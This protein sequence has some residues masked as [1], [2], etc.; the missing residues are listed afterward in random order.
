MKILSAP[1][2]PTTKNAVIGIFIIE[3]DSSA[4]GVGSALYQTRGENYIALIDVY[5]KKYPPHMTNY[6]NSK[7]ELVGLALSVEHWDTFARLGT[8]IIF[9]DYEKIADITDKPITN[10]LQGRMVMLLNK[11]NLII[12]HRQGSKQLIS[13]WQSRFPL[14]NMVL[15]TNDIIY[16]KW[17]S[18]DWNEQEWIQDNIKDTQ[19]NCV[20]PEMN[21]RKINQINSKKICTLDGIIEEYE[22][23][24]EMEAYD[25]RL[26]KLVQQARENTNILGYFSN[27]N[28]ILMTLRNKKR[29]NYNEND[30][31]NNIL[32]GVVE[33]DNEVTQEDSKPCNEEKQ[34]K[35]E[36]LDYVEKGIYHKQ[37]DICGLNRKQVR[38]EQRWDSQLGIMM[39]Y[40]QD[41]GN[42][43]KNIKDISIY[44]NINNINID[45]QKLY[46]TK[47][48]LL[49][50][51]NKKYYYNEYKY[52]I[53][54][55]LA[56]VVIAYVHEVNGHKGIS[57]TITLIYKQFMLLVSKTFITKILQSCKECARIA[58]LQHI[59]QYEMKSIIPKYPFYSIHMDTKYVLKDIHGMRY[60]HG[61][62]DHFSKYLILASSKDM[63]AET[64]LT[65]TMDKVLLVFGI[66]ERYIIDNA[67]NLNDE[68]AEDI[69]KIVGI[70]NINTSAYYSRSNGIIE[71]VWKFIDRLI[72]LY[73]VDRWSEY[74]V[75]IQYLWN[76]DSKEDLAG[77]NPSHIIF[78]SLGVIPILQMNNLMNFQ[79]LKELPW[80]QN[81]KLRMSKWIDAIDITVQEIINKVMDSKDKYYI[82]QNKRYS[83]QYKDINY[84]PGDLVK[85]RV[86]Y[87]LF[88]KQSDNWET[89]YM[90]IEDKGTRVMIKEVDTGVMTTVN[91]N[92][93]RPLMKD[94]F[95]INKLLMDYR[96]NIFDKRIRIKGGREVRDEEFEDKKDEKDQED[97]DDNED[98]KDQEDSDDNNESKEIILNENVTADL[99]S[100]VLMI[101]GGE[102]LEGEALITI[103]K[104]YTL[105]WINGLGYTNQDIG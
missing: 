62:I 36:W 68:I 65:F 54:D 76:M 41:N 30:I 2:L 34:F 98:H 23:V 75:W 18:E 50:Y 85:L 53:P 11:Y 95:K 47:D 31:F 49:I 77:Y 59:P 35:N 82:K 5:S 39:K 13:D 37:N 43:N 16:H 24:I 44:L 6:H 69:K 84:N 25:E 83:K 52:V 45:L 51:Q 63:N 71:N 20:I 10:T 12:K 3:V 87:G 38:E 42:R 60:I 86:S 61:W 104:G 17:T 22:K 57:K 15:F 80:I 33:N 99:D 79:A 90:V 100:K 46:L 70:D 28:L 56:V 26:K 72:R 93:L 40:L 7:L 105:L 102:Q 14:E 4:L 89:G 66:P 9:C 32:D 27:N 67:S 55:S 91:K 103:E 92:F 74:L 78:G 8:T 88:E 58:N 48:G 73:G 94:E 97:S 1:E 64:I 101:S 81:G 96:K 19:L 29:I 21:V